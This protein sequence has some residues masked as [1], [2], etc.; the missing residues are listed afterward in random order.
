VKPSSVFTDLAGSEWAENAITA[1]YK[2]GIV[3]G[4][5]D[6]RFYPGNNIT[7]EEFVKL[8]IEAFNIE[9]NDENTDF[10]DVAKGAWYCKY[11]N[12]AV[13]NG[14]VTGKDNGTFGIG[15]NITRQDMAVI[16]YRTAKALGYEFGVTKEVSFTDSENI[17]DYAVE[18]VMA[19]SNAGIINGMENGVFAPLENATRAQGAQIIYN[20]L[21]ERGD[22]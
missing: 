12:A 14:I 19:L 3:S 8:V 20:V 6:G 22:V 5:G 16:L 15:E 1:L 7:R 2:K 4:S 17:S 9:A 11:I 10:A 21:S 18:A 13:N